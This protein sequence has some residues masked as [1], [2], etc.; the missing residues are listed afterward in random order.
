MDNV[1]EWVGGGDGSAATCKRTGEAYEGERRRGDRE[2]HVR[3][4]EH[5]LEPG[6]L[7]EGKEIEICIRGCGVRTTMPA[8]HRRFPA[9][10]LRGGMLGYGRG[11]WKS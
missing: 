7:Q 9:G 3:I 5:N 4:C 8:P 2:V 6:R 11:R 10:R 1:D